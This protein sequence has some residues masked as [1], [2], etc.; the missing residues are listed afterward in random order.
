[1]EFAQACRAQGVRPI[2]GAELTVTDGRRASRPIPPDAPRRDG[3]R[4]PQPLPARHRGA[5]RHPANPRPRSPPPRPAARIAGTASEGLVCLS[6]CAREGAL[7]GSWERGELERAPGAGRPPQ[8]GLRAR[9][10]SGSSCSVPS[11]GTTEP[12]TAGSSG[13]PPGWACRVSRPE[14]FTCTGAHGRRSRTRWWRCACAARSRRPSPSGAPTAAPTS[15]RPPRW[16]CAFATTPTPS[17]SRAS[18]PS[19]F[20]STSPETSAT[21]I[22]GSEDEGAD[23]ALA[24]LCRARLEHRY[25]GM[26]EH[27][28]ADAAPG[29]RAGADQEAGALRL[30]PPALR[31]PRAGARCRRGGEGPRLGPD[32]AAARR[33]GAARASARSS[34][35]SPASRT[36]IRCATACSSGAS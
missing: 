24:E 17:P 32:A 14:T 28:E 25:A 11:G 23:R 31:H 19:D 36:S 5:P 8:G 9:R 15:L 21:A 13:S 18:L 12:A 2:T 4:V 30:L 29:G 6:G 16:R 10:A 7:A 27:G 26:R 3:N 1:M 34:A 22:P 20:D 33:V 35:T